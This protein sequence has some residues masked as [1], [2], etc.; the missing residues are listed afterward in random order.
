MWEA[1][2]HGRA[3]ITVSPMKHNWAVKFLSHEVFADLD[4]LEAAI[5]S[6]QLLARLR[7]LSGERAG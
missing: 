4:A 2:E 6:G 7:E 5:V 1:Y 3:V